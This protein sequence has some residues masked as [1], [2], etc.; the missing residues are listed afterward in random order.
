M[1]Q[2]LLEWEDVPELAD[3]RTFRALMDQATE[4]AGDIKI[5]EGQYNETRKE[6]D[7]IFKAGNVSGGVMYN[8]WRVNVVDSSGK[9]KVNMSKLLR[10]LGPKGPSLVKQAMEPGKPTHYIQI[11]PPSDKPTNEG[12]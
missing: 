5:L 10:L 1:T 9:P 3:N 6:I 11:T 8:G 4:L 2:R 12:E 7:E